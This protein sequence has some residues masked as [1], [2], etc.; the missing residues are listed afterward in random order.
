[1]RTRLY[2][3]FVDLTKAFGTANREGLWKIM[4]KFGCPERFTQMVRQFHNAYST[5]GQLLNHRRMHFQS[6]VSTTIVHE[7]LFADD[8]ALNTTMEGD[9]QRSMDP[10]AA[11]CDNFSLAIYTEKTVVMNQ[12][13]PNA[14]CIAP[15]L[16]VNGAPLQ[17]ADNF[18]YL[19]STLSRTTKTDDE[20][21]RR[22]SRASQAIDRLKSTV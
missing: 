12:P 5:D 16:N 17:V 22:I 20:V 18:Y 7:L 13:P 3:T 19:G 9:M 10:F 14:A 15:Q 8:C 11:A 6:R 21:A 4:Q 1:M 2:C